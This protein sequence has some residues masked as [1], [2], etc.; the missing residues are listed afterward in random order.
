VYGVLSGDE[1]VLRT[2]DLFRQVHV[3]GWILSNYW[4]IEE[5]RKEF[6]DEV[7]KLLESKVLQP[8]AGEKF[9]LSNF[10]VAI[11][12]SEEVARGGKVFLES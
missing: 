9:D 6:I 10:K 1:V 7:W 2:N 8:Y 5:K 11:Q 3:A 12:K 4:G